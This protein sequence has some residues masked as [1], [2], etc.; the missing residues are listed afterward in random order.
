MRAGGNK[1]LKDFMEEFGI[2]ANTEIEL[3][4]NLVALD[5]YRKY[6]VVFNLDES[7]C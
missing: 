5:Y 6:V 4:Y 7:G 3:K 1:K 2:P